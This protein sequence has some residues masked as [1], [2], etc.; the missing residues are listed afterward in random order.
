MKRYG[1]VHFYFLGD[2]KKLDSIAWSYKKNGYDV[3]EYWKDESQIIE[4]PI[5][6][7]GYEIN[8]NYNVIL[9]IQEAGYE[10]EQPLIMQTIYKLKEDAN[11]NFELTEKQT[12]IINLLSR[13]YSNKKIAM[14][15]G[16]K[17]KAVK[18]HL[19]YMLK[20]LN[21]NRMGAALSWIKHQHNLE[22]ENL[23]NEK[24]KKIDM[25]R[26]IIINNLKK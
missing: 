7:K 1:H 9:N 12:E 14:S 2:R 25:L 4:K 13:G 19:Y 10:G 17:E 20:K 21:T 11:K 6:F 22:L 23:M 16:V 26:D 24:N 18:Y 5:E 15:L 3:K 8:L